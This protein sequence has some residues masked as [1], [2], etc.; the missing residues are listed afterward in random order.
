MEKMIDLSDIPSLDAQP[1]TILQHNGKNYSIKDGR[2]TF[3]DNR[4]YYDSDGNPWPSVTTILDAY[5][6]DVAF[7]EWLKKAGEDADSIRDEAGNRGSMVHK[8]TEDFDNGLD[9]N[10]LNNNGEIDMPLAAWAMF[11]RYVEFRNTVPWF[12]CEEIEASFCNPFLG[13]GGTRDRIF[14]TN[15]LRVLVDIKTSNYMHDYFYLQLVAYREAFHDMLLRADPSGKLLAEKFIHEVAILWLNAKTRTAKDESYSGKKIEDC[16]GPGW[17][18]I[19]RPQ[20]DLPKDWAM[21][22]LVQQLWRSKNEGMIPKQIAYKIGYP[23]YDQMQRYEEL[24]AASLT[25]EASRPVKESRSSK[26]G[27]Q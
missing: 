6:K 15:G 22:R 12:S 1:M 20:S 10:L 8:L 25:A 4:F 24:R 7:Y 23:A 17:Q 26:N 13:Y 18:F 21:F 2:L 5:P 3:L 27:K 16:Q 19:V 14:S 11:E 9:V